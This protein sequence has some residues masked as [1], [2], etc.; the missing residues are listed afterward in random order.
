[1]PHP[2]RS[3]IP[4]EE[5]VRLYFDE[6][7]SIARIAERFR[8]NYDTIQ[9]RLKE[10]GRTRG[11]LN[12]GIPKRKIPPDLLRE[13][14]L[15]E[16]LSGHRIAERLGEAQATVYRRL[17]D[18]GLTGPATGKRDETE[19]FLDDLRPGSPRRVAVE[20]GKP[21]F[22]TRLR[23]LAKR[24]GFRVAIAKD[25]EDHVVVTRLP[26]K[27]VSK[28]EWFESIRHLYCDEKRRVRRIAEELG[29]SRK[30][31]YEV[32]KSAGIRLE[33]R[34]KRPP[35]ERI[36]KHDLDRLYNG[37][38]LPVPAIAKRLKV[39]VRDVARELQRHHIWS[40]ARIP[41]RFDFPQLARL[42]LWKE[43]LAQ[44]DGNDVS[45]NLRREAKWHN[46]RIAVRSDGAGRFRV[47][48]LPFPTEDVV[49][50]LLESGLSPTKAA[51]KLMVLPKTIK[52]LLPR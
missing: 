48:R 8:A 20:G 1:M 30:H 45:R 44:S 36:D 23:R 42:P 7:W 3:D 51:K 13:L 6:H 40:D 14:Y 38:R 37:E 32:I 47:L 49:A 12:K 16:G 2:R 27:G 28:D 21:A 15:G 31:V 26:E 19:S 41:V 25:G 9:L 43:F 18:L 5:V 17:K 33:D 35:I 22:T 46:I 11:R 34:G 24:R 4:D 52:N 10:S 39:T 50:G 29:L